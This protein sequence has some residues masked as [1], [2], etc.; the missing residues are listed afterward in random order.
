MKS[1]EKASSTAPP[2]F[3]N[4]TYLLS[5]DKYGQIFMKMPKVVKLMHLFQNCKQF[6]LKN[7]IKSKIEILQKPIHFPSKYVFEQKI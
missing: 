6:N 1:E 5:S 4:G 2:F 7:I 3:F